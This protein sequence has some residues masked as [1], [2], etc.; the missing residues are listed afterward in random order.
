MDETDFHQERTLPSDAPETQASETA[1]LPSV[2]GPYVIE[3][4]FEKGGMSLLYLG[5]HPDTFEITTIK[6]LS[7]KYLSNPEVVDRF[8]KEAT[9]IAMADHPNIVKL[10]GHG[11]WEGGLYIAMEFIE[12]ISLRQLIVST[13]LSLKRALEIVIEIAYALC[14]LHMHGVIHRDLKPENILIK[15]DGSVKVIDF[16][17]AQLLTE[18]GEPGQPSKQRLIGTPI[19]M[20]PEQREN[21]ESVSYPSDIYS[22]GIIAYEAVL[23]KL[24]HGQIHLGLMPKGLRKIL[25]KALQPK[26]ED[27]YQDVVDFIADLSNYLNSSTIKEE[28]HSGDRITELSENLKRAQ[29]ILMPE[30]SPSWPNISIGLSV[31]KNVSVSG[32]L[33]DYFDIPENAYGIITS[34]STTKDAEGFVYTAA[35]RGMIRALCRLTTKPDELITLMNDLIVNDP[36]RHILMLNYLILQPNQNALQYICCGSGHLWHHSQ[37]SGTVEKVINDNPAVGAES[38]S[39][40]QGAT[41]TWNVGDT[42]VL[43]SFSNMNEDQFQKILLESIDLP[44]QQQVDVLMKRMKMLSPASFNNR[45][46]CLISIKR[47]STTNRNK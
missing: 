1:K 8:L 27:R 35:A 26:T 37:D 39:Q 30:T 44:P 47:T 6:V 25:T 5:R 12:G 41:A 17:I 11:Q 32:V 40:F 24:S 20:S 43:S 16:G 38:N 9:I 46:A 21:P 3:K 45:S 36:M 19:Y 23:G 14:H 22:L 33:H 31:H 10:F 13:P 42:I 15:E 29:M 34:E 2:I 7:Q 4:L 28:K 18:E